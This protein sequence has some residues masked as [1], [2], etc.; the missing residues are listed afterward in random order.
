MR[1]CTPKSF[2][3]Y[4]TPLIKKNKKHKG[5][6]QGSPMSGVLSNIYMIEFDKNLKKYIEQLGGH[7][8]R[9]CDDLLCIL[10]IEDREQIFT[11]SSSLENYVY[12]L[13]KKSKLDVNS[14]KT[15]KYAFMPMANL[16]AR[17]SHEN[18]ERYPLHKKNQLACARIEE[19]E[20]IYDRLQYLGFKFDG[21]KVTIRSS[22]LMRYKKKMRR[23]INYHLRLKLS[24]DPDGK[25]KTRKLY[26]LYGYSFRGISNFP[27]YAKRASEEFGSSDIRK[28]LSGRTKEIKTQISVIEKRIEKRKQENDY[29]T[30]KKAK[31]YK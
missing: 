1:I 29:F 6:P 2:K 8:I 19:N 21:H 14:K 27:T 15:E 16:G 25:L 20:L 26:F 4:V 17:Y 5:I 18:S 24:N 28:Q 10:P 7:Y 11:K 9:Y 3:K 31:Y 12:S 23:G 30:S 13:A 22:S